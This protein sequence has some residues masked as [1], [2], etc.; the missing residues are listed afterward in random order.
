M[1]NLL[2]TTGLFFISFFK[3]FSQDSEGL[4]YIIT[5]SDYK[6]YYIKTS[7]IKKAEYTNIYKAW[8]YVYPEEGHEKEVRDKMYKDYKDIK[9]QDYSYEKIYYYVNCKEDEIGLKIVVSYKKNGEVIYS[10]ENY[11][12]DYST[13]IPDS[14][15]EAIFEYVCS[16]V[17][18]NQIK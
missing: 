1:K 17:K 10:D 18:A 2:L 4:D 14:V 13:V 6:S 15:G 5:S 7:T 16:Y 12:P 3:I 11:Y 8:L 9:Y